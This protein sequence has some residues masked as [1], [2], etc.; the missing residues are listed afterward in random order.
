[1]S[2]FHVVARPVRQDLRT[3]VREEALTLCGAPAWATDGFG[4]EV[5]YA[6]C[7]ECVA[8]HHNARQEVTV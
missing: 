1:M 6:T 7:P 2:I 4:I 3:G 8:A 5:K